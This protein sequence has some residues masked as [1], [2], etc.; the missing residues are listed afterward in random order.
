MEKKIDQPKK[1]HE[2]SYDLLFA[3]RIS[4]EKGVLDLLKA[5]KNYIQNFDKI[6]VL[7][8]GSFLEKDREIISNYFTEHK[9]AQYVTFHDFDPEIEKYIL[10]SKVVILPSHRENVPVILLESLMLEKP[11]IA[12]D[13]GNVRVAVTPNLNGILVHPQNI[14]Q[15]EAAIHQMLDEKKYK[16]Y[17]AG[18]KEIKKEILSD[19]SNYRELEEEI[20]L[21][22]K[23]NS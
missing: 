4:Q 20:D 5:I 2:L 9:L 14:Q 23:E 22:I 17:L 12:T 13:V 7:I 8:I 16:Q 6:K 21:L 19:K 1:F 15:L 10:D 3:G 11:V 18:A